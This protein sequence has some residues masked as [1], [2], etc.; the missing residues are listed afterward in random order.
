MNRSLSLWVKKKIF[1]TVKPLI[2]G[3]QKAISKEIPR[4]KIQPKNIEHTSLLLDREDLLKH[5][6]QRGV[7][8]EL[9]VDTGDFSELI[10]TTCK[11]KK[12]HLVDFWG[13]KR[14]NQRKKAHV[15]E[16]FKSQMN[17][18]KVEINLGYSTVVGKTFEDNYFDW[19][20][21][22]TD[23]SYKTTIC[24]L[25]T[26]NT[27]VKKNGIIAGHD[28]II[29]N[30]DGLVRYGVKEAVYEFC[31]KHNWQIL[32]LTMEIDD[33]PSFAIRRI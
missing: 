12:L 25:E 6:P 11:P 27:K 29:G 4:F 9:G 31:L 14:Y 13:T 26:W 22:D 8:A 17:S 33:H 20:Y 32:Y 28:F 19:I 23:H 5:L 1:K 30:W 15:E 7:I 18:G 10:L 24:E 21:I 3:Y 16:R 2:K